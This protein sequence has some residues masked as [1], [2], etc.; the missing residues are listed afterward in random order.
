ML[1]IVGR[2]EEPDQLV[3]TEDDGKSLGHLGAGNFLDDPIHTQG[4]AVEELQGRANLAV[5]APGDVMLLDEVERVQSGPVRAQGAFGRG[6]EVPG[7]TGN[8][9]N[10]LSDRPRREIAKRHH[11]L[12]HTGRRSG[13]MT[14]S[15]FMEGG[16]GREVSPRP[17]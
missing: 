14:S 17:S 10:V 11:V 6:V 16:T 13:V 15:L 2:L 5:V 3:R 1:E 7:A 8:A 4:Y 12:G 9:V